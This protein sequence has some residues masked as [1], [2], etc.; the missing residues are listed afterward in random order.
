MLRPSWSRVLP[1]SAGVLLATALTGC[2]LIGPAE[3]AT[4]PDAGQASSATTDAR[5]VSLVQRLG[6]DGPVRT[7][8]VDPSGRWQC[9]DCAGDGVESTGSLNPEQTRRLQRMLADP[10]LAQETDEARRYKQ[11]C[12]DALTSTLLIPPG[13]T[14][15]SQDCPGEEKPPVANRILLLLTQVTPAEDKG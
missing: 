6:I 12:I 3:G 13:L 10:A 5:R 1:G 14:I 9:R 8:D 7:L 15:T 4:T 11:S 2:S